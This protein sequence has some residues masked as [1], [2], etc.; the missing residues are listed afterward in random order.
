MI[1][2]L[3]GL[4]MISAIAVLVAERD[5]V[6]SATPAVPLSPDTK[7]VVLKPKT[8]GLADPQ[9][10]GSAARGQESEAAFLFRMRRLD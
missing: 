2:G 8:P 7:A 9:D 1:V 10:V 4:V 6:G 3:A 5:P